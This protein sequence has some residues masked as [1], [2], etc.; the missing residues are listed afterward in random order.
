MG[1]GGG[2]KGGCR[3]FAFVMHKIC[4][5]QWEKIVS[6]RC[7]LCIVPWVISMPTYYCRRLSRLCKD[8]L[9]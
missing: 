9:E 2:W 7:I 6:F 3:C 5:I 1:A 4:K 8:D